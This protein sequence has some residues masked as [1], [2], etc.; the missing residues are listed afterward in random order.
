MREDYCGEISIEKLGELTL[1]Q[2]AGGKPEGFCYWLEVKTSSYGQ[3]PGRKLGK[4]RIWLSRSDNQWRYNTGSFSSI[5]DALTRLKKGLVEL[6]TAVKEGSSKDLNTIGDKYLGGRRYSLKGEP[7]YLYFPDK[8]LPITNPKHLQYFL[9]IVRHTTARRLACTQSS[10]AKPPVQPTNLRDLTRGKWWKFLY[11]CLPPKITTPDAA[12]NSEIDTDTEQEKNTETLSKELRQLTSLVL[13]THNIILYGPPGTGKTYVVQEF[14]SRFLSR[15][16]R[17][18]KRQ[19][20]VPTTWVN[21]RKARLTLC[22]TTIRSSLFTSPL[23]TRNLS[24]AL[25]RYCQRNRQLPGNITDEQA[26]GGFGLKYN[27]VPGIFRKMCERAEVDWQRYPENTPK[28]LL[29]IDEINRANIAKVFGELITL[30]EDDKR[31]G[32]DQALTVTLPYSGQKFREYLQISIFW[33][34]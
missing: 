27:V 4:I 34:Q 26:N 20:C 13:R 12:I 32:R 19:F 24:R 10:T 11:D 31:L 30:V 2:Y 23:L 5:E 14:A 17:P 29:V 22:R 7:L 21:T 16:L 28:Y 8:F 18:E 33:A 15:Q 25:S 6:T 3:R 1:E 9:R